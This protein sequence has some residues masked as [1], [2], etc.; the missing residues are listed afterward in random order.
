MTLENEIGISS[1][2]NE[3]QKASISIL[4]THGIVFNSYERFFKEHDL[5][6]QQ[7]NILRILHEQYPEPVTTSFLR[8]KML[9]KMSD[10]SRLVN[11]LANKGLVAVSPN[12]SDKRLVNIVISEKGLETIYNVKEQYQIIDELLTGLSEE[13]AAQ[14]T[15]LLYKVRESIQNVYD[16]RAVKAD[17]EKNQTS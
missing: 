15:K 12:T 14:L 5:T 17:E 3:W 2:R 9:D 1:F 4:Y 10:A 6:T 7:Y 8:E 13:E 16:A 11:R